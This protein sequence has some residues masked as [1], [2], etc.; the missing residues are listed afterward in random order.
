MQLRPILAAQIPITL[1]I[2]AEKIKVSG[3]CTDC[4]LVL[5]ESL[6]TFGPW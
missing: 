4:L 1:G 5:A 3:N 6:R 2:I